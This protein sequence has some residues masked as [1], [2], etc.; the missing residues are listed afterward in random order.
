MKATVT[1]IGK[2]ALDGKEPMIILFGERATDSL[3]EYSVIQKFEESG[4]LDVKTGAQLKIDDAVYQ[5]THVGS[6]ANANLNS[7]SHV[8]LVF[9][10]VPE[11]DAVVNGIYLSPTTVPT[12]KVGSIIEY[13]S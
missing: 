2:H 7:I 12:V 4:E 13:I 10:E 11:E 6:F 1:E 3:R 8:T 9:S 5:V